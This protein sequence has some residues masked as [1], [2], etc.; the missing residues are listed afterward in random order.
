MNQE[1]KTCNSLTISTAG[2]QEDPEYIAFSNIKTD[3][4]AVMGLLKKYNVAN[5]T[6]IKR[7]KIFEHEVFL[8]FLGEGKKRDETIMVSN[9]V[10]LRDFAKYIIRMTTPR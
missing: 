2:S 5:N 7:N 10:N 4:S 8:T 1:L 6:Y 9:N 3:I